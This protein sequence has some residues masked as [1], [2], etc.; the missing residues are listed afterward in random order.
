M[1]IRD[2]GMQIQEFLSAFPP[3]EPL[4]SPLTPFMEVQTSAR[5]H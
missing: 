3:F 5:N 4:V 1:N 2:T